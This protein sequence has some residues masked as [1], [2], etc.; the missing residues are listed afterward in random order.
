MGQ[1]DYRQRRREPVNTSLCAASAVTAPGRSVSIGSARSSARTVNP[2]QVDPC[3]TLPASTKRQGSFA[4]LSPAP[5]RSRPR[6]PP[7]S[8]CTI[9]IVKMQN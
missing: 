8:T 3:L 4:K 6:G 7:A 2:T 1:T 9:R 5:C